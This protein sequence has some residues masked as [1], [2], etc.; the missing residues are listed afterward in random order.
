MTEP[1]PKRGTD[2]RPCTISSK[3]ARWASGTLSRVAIG[4]LATLVSWSGRS[5]AR[6]QFGAVVAPQHVELQRDRR[7]EPHRVGAV[8]LHRIVGQRMDQHVEATAVQHQPLDDGLKLLGSEDD[9]GIGDR[10]WSD[11][12]VPQA[13]DLH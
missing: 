6:Q 2:P 13:A 3:M 11:R 8:I 9:L 5:A 4:S 10:V 7:T 1:G 12:L